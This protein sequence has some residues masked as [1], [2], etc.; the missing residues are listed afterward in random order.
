MPI[1][2]KAIEKLDWVVRRGAQAILVRSTSVTGYCVPRSFT[3][4]KFDPFW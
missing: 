2:D 3:V 1:V 4:L